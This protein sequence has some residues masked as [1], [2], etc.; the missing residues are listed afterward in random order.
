MFEEWQPLE[1][2]PF[3]FRFRWRDGDNVEHDSM[4]LAWEFGETW[5]KY[6][7]KY[8]DPISVM[9]DKWLKDLCGPDWQV[10][11]FMGNLAQRR[12]IYAVC[13]VFGPPKK[14]TQNETLW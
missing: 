6:R 7:K 5:R 8:P 14:A 2:V 11:F 10:S 13:G 4:V 12:H 1:K 9:R 3:D